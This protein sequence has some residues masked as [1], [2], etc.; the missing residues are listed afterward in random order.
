MNFKAVPLGRIALFFSV[1]TASPAAGIITYTNPAAWL[2]AA[3][4]AKDILSADGAADSQ[5]AGLV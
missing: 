3:T 2:S 5:A 4:F 1:L